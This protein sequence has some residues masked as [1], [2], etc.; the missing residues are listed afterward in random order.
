MKRRRRERGVREKG[1]QRE[2]TKLDRQR[3]TTDGGQETVNEGDEGE[4]RRWQGRKG[5]RGWMANGR[6]KGEYGER[7]EGQRT[8]GRTAD[9][10]VGE[11]VEECAM[12]KEGGRKESGRVGAGERERER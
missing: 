12:E 6:R 3:E 1:R 9:W 4:A 5:G 7:R 2:T 8:D 10:L 11:G